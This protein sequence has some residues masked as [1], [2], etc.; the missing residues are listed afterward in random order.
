MICGVCEHERQ[1]DLFK[2]SY[3]DPL[4]QICDEC[5]ADKLMEKCIAAMYRLSAERRVRVIAEFTEGLGC[6]I[7]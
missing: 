3:D 5:K 1:Y 2:A 7:C 4:K 6:I